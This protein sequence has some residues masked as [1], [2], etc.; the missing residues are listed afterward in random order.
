VI[1]FLS[2]KLSPTTPAYGSKRIELQLQSI[3]SIASGDSCQTY[4]IGIENHW[5]THVDCPAH[6]FANGKKVS[7]Y[8]A[9][10]WHFRKPQVLEITVKPGQVI[11]KPDLF[12]K[13]NP[14]TD[15]L[16]LKSGWGKFRDKNI[17]SFQNP[18]L[19]PIVGIW[20]KKEYPLIRAIGFDWISISSYTNRKL[21]REAHKTFLDPASE[22]NPIL[23]IEDMLLLDD[24]QNLSQVWVVP[25]RIEG[26]DSAPC[27]VIG[28]FE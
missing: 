22:G 28:V 1:K 15:L 11:G 2:Y 26:I 3:K 14:E 9:D 19:D 17:Y 18:G 13:I 27:T 10:F 8:D 7:D 25:F 20:L 23:I 6:F 4:W 24:M 12:A 21:G 16:L 5:G